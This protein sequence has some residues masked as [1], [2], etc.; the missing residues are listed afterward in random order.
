MR[1]INFKTNG[2]RLVLVELQFL[3]KKGDL[4]STETQHTQQTD[5]V[6]I[7]QFETQ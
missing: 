3:V 4:V 5:R 2:G 1:I 6:L 7:Y